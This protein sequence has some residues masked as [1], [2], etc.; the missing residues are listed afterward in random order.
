MHP[1]RNPVL[2]LAVVLAFLAPAAVRSQQLVLEL[3]PGVVTLAYCDSAHVINKC[4]FVHIDSPA[5]AIGGIIKL[6]GQ[7]YVLDWTGPGYHLDS[8]VILQA[9]GK[10]RSGLAGQPWVEV[11]P[12]PGRTHVSRAWRDTNGDRRLSVT[13][14]LTL[15]DGLVVQIKDVRL[16]LRV[17]PVPEHPEQPEQ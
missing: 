6:D 7:S 12:E 2:V 9:Q 15:E 4:N 8:G 14:T 1:L 11:Y 3:D 5:V 16:N 10:T 13:D 17:S